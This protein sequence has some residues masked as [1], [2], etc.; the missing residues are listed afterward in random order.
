MP[1]IYL[2]RA[3]EGDRFHYPQA[4]NGSWPAGGKL[5]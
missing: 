2:A 5:Y 1:C 3:V 4:A